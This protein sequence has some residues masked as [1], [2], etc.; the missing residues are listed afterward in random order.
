MVRNVKDVLFLAPNNSV[1]P[2]REKKTV[3]LPHAEQDERG[4]DDSDEKASRCEGKSSGAT[5]YKSRDE[6]TN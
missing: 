3:N 5:A 4:D 6:N 2:L 1:I